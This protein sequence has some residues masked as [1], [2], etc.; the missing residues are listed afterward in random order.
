MKNMRT[1]IVFF[2]I[3]F[4]ELGPFFD[5]CSV[6]LWNLVNKISGENLMHMIVISIV[7]AC[8]LCGEQLELG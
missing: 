5:F 3:G 7:H 8:V 2:F 1:R 4:A 6:S